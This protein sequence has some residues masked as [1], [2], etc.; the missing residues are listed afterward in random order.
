MYTYDSFERQNKYDKTTE[1]VA[2]W[3]K[4][5]L[6]FSMDIYNSII[7]LEEPNTEE[8]KPKLDEEADA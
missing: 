2:Q 1:K 7:K 6:N 5:E 3:V 4:K 8:W